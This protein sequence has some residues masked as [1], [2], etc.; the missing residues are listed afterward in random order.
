MEEETFQT[1]AR[2]S[3]SY[4]LVLRDRWPVLAITVATALVTA[5]FLLHTL[6][7]KYAAEADVHVTPIQS[8]DDRFVGLGLLQE[9]NESRAVLTIAR[10]ADSLP[11]ARAAK[12]RI[13]GNSNPNT[14]LAEVKA[15]PQGQSN[16]VTI[17][18]RAASPRQAADV[19]NAFA[20]SVVALRT[21]QFQ[22]LLKQRIAHL[23]D[24]LDQLRATGRASEAADTSQ[25]IGLLGTYVGDKDPTV[26]LENT[27]VPQNRVVWPRTKLVLVVVTLAA[28]LL[29]GALL[30]ALEMLDPRVREER[31]VADSR[32]PILARLPRMTRRAATHLLGGTRSLPASV[33][34]SYRLLADKLFHGRDGWLD[35]PTVVLVTGTPASLSDDNLSKTVTA[36][37]LATL[38]ASAG[39]RT[40]LV[41]ADSRPEAIRAFAV[42]GGGPDLGNLLAGADARDVIRP[43]PGS[44]GWLSVVSSNGSKRRGSDGVAGLD[45]FGNRAV[46]RAF[47]QL[48]S[49]A[50][51]IVVNAPAVADAA[52]LVPFARA[53]DRIVIEVELGVTSQARLDE[54]IQ[55]FDEEGAEISGFVLFTRGRG[56]GT[57][58]RLTYARTIAPETEAPKAAA[59]QRRRE[60]PAAVNKPQS[61]ETNG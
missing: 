49:T 37:N 44:D 20:N 53:A 12:A 3:R 41:D 2:G 16:I 18:A 14:L 15:Q 26:G 22:E 50:D 43:V 19:A 17:A 61:L 55:A 28:L 29:A 54:L 58:G 59:R 1:G 33:L 38:S 32:K 57:G 24:R 60:G 4:W 46:A 31:Q 11:V 52:E 51:V 40:V 48:R 39:R 45:L 30:F 8:G 21:A 6:P 25:A 7:K 47:E 23:N 27:A 35:E 36:V 9:S 5:A 10:Y 13:G 34:A 56:R 42:N